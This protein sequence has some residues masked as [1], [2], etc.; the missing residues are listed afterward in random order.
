MKLFGSLVLAWTLCLGMFTAGCDKTVSEEQKVVKKSDGT[1][2]TD[3]EKTTQ[4]PDG[5]TKTTSEHK[6][7][8]SSP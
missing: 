4:A 6:V 1:T 2:V 3:K 8:K 5:G 7:D